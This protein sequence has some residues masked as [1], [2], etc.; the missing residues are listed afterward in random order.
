M[1]HLRIPL[2]GGMFGWSL[3]ASDDQM[4]GDARRSSRRSVP[5]YHRRQAG[6]CILT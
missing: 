2:G 4:R 6:G 1:V 5:R 3:E